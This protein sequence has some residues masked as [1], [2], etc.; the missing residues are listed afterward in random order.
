M[1]NLTDGEIESIW[2]SLTDVPFNED[3][4]GNLVLAEDWRQFTKGTNR[5]EIWHWFDSVYSRG[6]HY[7]LTSYDADV[8]DIAE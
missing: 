8:L 4:D 6:V 2:C 5:E 7:L 3:E 1:P